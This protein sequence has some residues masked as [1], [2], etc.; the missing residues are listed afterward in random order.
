MNDFTKEELGML[1]GGISLWRDEIT[2][3]EKKDDPY[4]SL[5]KKIKSMIENYC[6]HKG[7]FPSMNQST[8]LEC[9][10]CGKDNI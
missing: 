3:D 8:R 9:P 4:K 2:F 7:A 5:H 1:L 10:K 6:E